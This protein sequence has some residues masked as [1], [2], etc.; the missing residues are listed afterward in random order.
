LKFA[1]FSN[2][3]FAVLIFWF[4]PEL[5]VIKGAARSLWSNA[6]TRIS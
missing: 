5:S 1:T 6:R 4:C 2:V 3:S